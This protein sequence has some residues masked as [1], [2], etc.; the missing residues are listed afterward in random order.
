MAG[1]RRESHQGTPNSTSRRKRKRL[2]D[3]LV[4]LAQQPSPGLHKRRSSVSDAG[5]LSVS[6]SF[7]DCTTSPDK[8]LGVDG[9]EAVVV[10]TPRKGLTTRQQVF[11][12]L[13]Q[14]ESNYVDILETI[15][16]VSFWGFFK[17]FFLPLADF[18]LA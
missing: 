6:G 11:L 17:L 1:A 5:L 13:V 15:I 10:D 14:T 18:K 4:S 3:T 9:V 8:V 7:L 12:E 2:Q 16:T